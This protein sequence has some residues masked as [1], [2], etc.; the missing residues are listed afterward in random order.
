MITLTVNVNTAEAD[1][2]AAGLKNLT[3]LLRVMQRRGV[4]EIKKH[5]ADRNAEPNSMG[6][7]K[8][9]FW[10]REGRDNT[11]AGELTDHSAMIVVAS[12]AIAHKVKGGTITAKRG[13]FL[14]IPLTAEAYK[15]GSPSAANWPGLFVIRRKGDTS[16]AFLCLADQLGAK[17]P[18][19]KK[20]MQPRDSGIRPQWLLIKSVTQRA[21]PRALPWTRTPKS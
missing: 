16:R 14:A 12:A 7:A 21:D 17:P 2:A 15:A 1:T 18:K 4:N 20:A 10:N 6:W 9:N 13:K 11:G 5:F 3:P 19:G 8:K